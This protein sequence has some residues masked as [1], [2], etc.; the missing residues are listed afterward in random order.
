MVNA[1]FQ[2]YLIGD[3]GLHLAFQNK[4]FQIV[5]LLLNNSM[6]YI[7]QLNNYKKKVFDIAKTKYLMI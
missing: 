1:N 7:D 4:L 6:I 3:T 2:T 5:R